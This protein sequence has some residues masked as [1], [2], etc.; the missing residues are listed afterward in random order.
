MHATADEK[1]GD[2]SAASSA[3]AKDSLP[4]GKPTSAAGSAS[5]DPE[6]ASTGSEACENVA[7]QAE[8]P[9]ADVEAAAQ[10]PTGKAEQE[11]NYPS[12]KKVIPIMGGLYCAMLL[13]ALVCLTRSGLHTRLLS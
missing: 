13:V 7:P 3:P 2:G 1:S 10:L 8:V 5:Y 11:E 9:S 12:W 4:S 6:K